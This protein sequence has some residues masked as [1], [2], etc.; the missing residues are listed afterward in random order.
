MRGY[1]S[2]PLAYK[3]NI[4]LPVSKEKGHGIMAFNQED[5]SVA[6]KGGD[7]EPGYASL[8]AID[9]DG[10]EQIV[11]FTGK[12][13]MGLDPSNGGTKWSVDHPTQWSANISTPV[14]DAK[15]KNL[16]ISSA[17]GMGSRGVKL[18][19]AG[20][21]VVAK[22]VWFEPKMRIQHANAVRVGDWIYGSSGDMG[23]TFLACVN[24]RDGKFGWR[25]RG[26]AKANVLAADGKLIVL[27]EDGTLFLVKADPAKYRLLGKATGICK[28]TAWTVPTLVGRTLYLRDREKIVALD[29]GAKDKT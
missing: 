17:Y 15:D 25:Q 13:V 18:E 29:L 8:L 7:F 11:A 10:A 19:K 9:V 16:F 5:G 23:P 4:L 3:G 12:G 27:D 28:K 22:E 21:Q 6:W 24:V 2:S 14:W 1:G 20:S 26:I